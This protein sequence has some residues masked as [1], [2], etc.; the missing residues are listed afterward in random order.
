[1]LA[2]L[3]YALLAALLVGVAQADSEQFPI[4]G[5]YDLDASANSTTQTYIP[6]SY[7]KLLEASGVQTVPIFYHSSN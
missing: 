1:M 5:I 3:I 2:K 7:V 6:A 4:I